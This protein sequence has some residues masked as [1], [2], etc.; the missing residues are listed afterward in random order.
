LL[1]EQLWSGFPDHPNQSVAVSL[2]IQRTK[3]IAK[4]GINPPPAFSGC[5][6]HVK[7][8]LAMKGSL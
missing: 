2:R 8:R 1:A 5:G 4:P 6:F 3:F 7:E